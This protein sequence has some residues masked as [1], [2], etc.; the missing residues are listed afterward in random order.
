MAPAEREALESALRYFR[1]AAPKHTL[2]E[3]ESL[4]PRMRRLSN[5]PAQAALDRL[6]AL[7]EDHRRSVEGHEKVERLGRLWLKEGRLS[8]ERVRRLAE[9]LDRLSDIYQKHIH[10]EETDIFPLAGKTLGPSDLEEI[11]REMAARRGFAESK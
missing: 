9:T 1:E 11:G 8:E 5:R 6:D 3:E 4:F 2:D 10:T 7:E